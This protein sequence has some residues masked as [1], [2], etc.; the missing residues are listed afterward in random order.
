MKSAT[1][2]A[3]RVAPELRNQLEAVLDGN[4]SISAFVEEAVRS[5]VNYRR[6]QA[7]F[8]ARGEGAWQEYQR[9]G[10]SRPAAEVFDRIQGRIDARRQAL[11]HQS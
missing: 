2:P 6:I 10:Q 8:L 1:L 3:V 11:V 4:E 9:T 7:E 5:A